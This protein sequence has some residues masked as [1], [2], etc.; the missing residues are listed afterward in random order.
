MAIK[1]II[2]ALAFEQD[3]QHIAG[4]AVQLANE[5]NAQLIGVHV[6]EGIDTAE[7]WMPSSL[8][9]DAL[10]ARITDENRQRLS[11]TLSGTKIPAM[12]HVASG[13]PF[14]VIEDLAVSY[15]ADVVIIGAGV[16]RNAREKFFGSTADRLVR[17]SPCSVLVVRDFNI[18]AY[19]HVAI[20]V[21][22]SDHAKAAVTAASSLAPAASR[23]L[24]HAMEIPLA[25]EQAM[26]N[27]GTSQAEI[28]RYR[29]ARAKA[30]RKQIVDLFG[31]KGRLP[32]ATKIRIARGDPS[33]ALLTAS[34]RS[35]T[36]LVA[37]GT[38]G[39]NAVAQHLLGSVARKVLAGSGCDV[40][41]VSATASS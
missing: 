17:R 21:D 41:A 15:N 4:R 3:C 2:V 32:S 26:R 37:L 35:G 40:L 22:F 28:E 24:I 9:L 14:A 5:H 13:K 10:T 1:T 12:L 11:E 19:R 8:E 36:D 7:T 6:L 31:D 18:S 38:Q 27:T 34:R 25:F 30:A 39:N 23:E 20:G 16:A 33:S 29:Q